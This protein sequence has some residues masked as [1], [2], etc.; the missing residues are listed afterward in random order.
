MHY[1]LYMH[2]QWGGSSMDIFLLLPLRHWQRLKTRVGCS[3]HLCNIIQIPRCWI[4]D[5]A[6]KGSTGIEM[7]RGKIWGWKPQDGAVLLQR[8]ALI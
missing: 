8:P 5:D 1:M 4:F 2:Q 7:V 3:P 6:G